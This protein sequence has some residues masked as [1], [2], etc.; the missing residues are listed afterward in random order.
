MYIFS[1]LCCIV[2]VGFALG[3]INTDGFAQTAE[4]INPHGAIKIACQDCHTSTAWRPTRLEPAF[5]HNTQTEYPLTGTHAVTPCQGCHLEL[6]LDLPKLDGDPCGLC[7]V[8]IHQGRFIESCDTCHGMESF[9]EVNG[10][11]SHNQTA[12]PLTGA[13]RD[14]ACQSCH[15]EETLGGYTPLDSDCFSCHNGAFEQAPGHAERNFPFE[16]EQC[17]TSFSWLDGQFNHAV[18]AQGFALVGAHEVASCSSCHNEAGNFE[19]L[20]FPAD[21]ND[22][23]TC[24]EPAYE[25]IHAGSGF[26]TTCLD[27]HN[28][29]TWAGAQFNHAI[30]SQGFALVGAHQAAPCS[31]CHNVAANFEPLFSPANQNDCFSCHEAAYDRVHGGSGF[32]TNCL[33]C[34]N[35]TTWNR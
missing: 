32:S 28:T 30:V 8:D 6:R 1:R 16:C 31:S 23:F 17:H 34:H 13:H 33:D 3:G 9:E 2:L 5:D 25:R 35:T 24:H 19:P 27:C 10:D 29:D 4:S 21:Q 18:V 7:H 11:I 15:F 14:I 12:F 22:C 26:P 20:F